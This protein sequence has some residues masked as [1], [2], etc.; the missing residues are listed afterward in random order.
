MI[1]P[2]NKS[3]LMLL[4]GL[5][6]RLLYNCFS[7]SEKNG[8]C[9]YRTIGQDN[10]QQNTTDFTYVIMMSRH[11]VGCQPCSW[12]SQLHSLLKTTHLVSF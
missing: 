3:M 12:V 5:G 9:P 8:G 4:L 10:I 11:S 6:C 2:I 7:M 1:T